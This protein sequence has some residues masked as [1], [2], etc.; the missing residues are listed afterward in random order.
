LINPTILPEE[1][2]RTVASKT[3]W[4]VDALPRF[5][6]LAFEKDYHSFVVERRIAADQSGVPSTG[7]RTEW[8][9]ILDGE[10][11]DRAPAF[12]QDSERAVYELAL[13]RW[14]RRR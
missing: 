14:E 3:P 8:V 11:I 9:I 13:L 1:E 4:S 5:T 2:D 10:E 7:A 12:D 6:R